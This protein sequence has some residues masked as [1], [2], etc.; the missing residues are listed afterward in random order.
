MAESCH[1]S[2]IIE[3]FLCPICKADL[4]SFHRLK[5]HFQENHPE[6]QDVLKS[7]KDLFG[8][9]TKKILL[10]LDEDIE[11]I[12][13]NI[14]QYEIDTEVQEI[15]YIRTHTKYFKAVRC[16]RLEHFATETNKLIIR[17]DQLLRVDSASDRRQREQQVV[18]WLDG[19]S[20]NLCPQC[21]RSFN[22]T[23]RQHHCRLCGA[24][25]CHSCTSFLSDQVARAIISGLVSDNTDPPRNLDETNSLRLCT[26]CNVL[27]ESRRRLQMNRNVHP[28]ICDL[29]NELCLSKRKIEPDVEQYTKM[30]ASL[31]AGESTYS[32]SDTQILRGSIA[33]QGET[34]DFIS[35]KIAG[36][37]LNPDIPRALNLQ[38]AIRRST[39]N[40]IKDC[41]LSLPSVP[42]PAE[43]LEKRKRY[44]QDVPTVHTPQMLR[45]PRVTLHSGW[46]PVAAAEHLVTDTASDPL[47]QQMNIVKGYIRQAREAMRFEEVASL[48]AHVRELEEAYYQQSLAHST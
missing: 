1:E 7:L 2:D 43:L 30:C 18:E 13:A 3:G 46:S 15:G 34:L 29:Y 33:K 42:S 32:L 38:A 19:S 6:D 39:S 25:M 40:Y 47:I 4:K 11:S 21:A 5:T 17:L 26:H 48:E 31:H 8:K 10:K 27:L 14:E 24:I 16:S 9:A 36:I 12:K 20:V 37:P 23:R 44:Q 45:P 28:I 35:K 22:L 41:L